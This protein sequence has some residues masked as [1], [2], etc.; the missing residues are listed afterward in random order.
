MS[1]PH[2][3]GLFS[4]LRRLLDTVLA[5][6][7]NRVELF[8][9][10]LREE[11][12][13]LIE[14]IILAVVVVAL[15]TVTLTLVTLTIVVLLWDTARVAALVSVSVLYLVATALVARALVVRLKAS[16][17]FSATLEELKKDRECL[18]AEK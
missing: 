16:R 12:C 5:T 4:S 1:D 3:P 17:P 8:A 14:A 18:R 2:E 10:E 6:V 7:Q 15:A 9:V 13:R 11:K